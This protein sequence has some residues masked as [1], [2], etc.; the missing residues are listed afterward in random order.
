M[1]DVLVVGNGAREHALA[2]KLRQSGDVGRLI[3]APGNGG[4]AAIAENVP[5]PADDIDGLRLL[6]QERSVGLTVVGPEVPL[7]AGLANAFQKHGLPVFGATREASRLEWSKSFARQLTQDLGLPGPDFRVF[8]DPNDCE[9]FLSRHEDPIVVKADGLAA[10]KGALLCQ[11]RAEALAAAR[12]CMR[13]R[14]FGPAGETV[15]LEEFLT[16]QEISVFAF[17]DGSEASQM[18]AACDYKRALECDQGLNTGG[19]GAYAPSP[20]W[21]PALSERVH[22]E[23]IQPT[24]VAMEQRGTPYRG[25][26]YAG[27]ML[28]EEGP[29]LLEFNCR[30]GDPEAQ[31]VL[32]L[33]ESD[34]LPVLQACA[35]GSI[36]QCEVRWSVEACV[37]VVMVSGGY[38]GEY[39][40]GMTIRGLDDVDGD[41]LVFH[42]GTVAGHAPGSQGL[43]TDGGRVLTVVGQGND[44]EQARQRAYANISRIRFED[45]YYRRDIGKLAPEPMTGVP[46]LT[47]SAG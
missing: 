6:A 45:S 26:L 20:T 5:V 11:D 33:L 42:A 46:G 19:M 40:R 13:E 47:K 16:G 36:S 9:D 3:V 23:I 4:T 12:Q 7:A 2:W 27:L 29:K 38:P 28:T 34:L 24:I 22:R 15:V 32:P 31:V 30:L 35:S 17:C 18:V 14:A 21:T 1:T 44:V 25:V 41:V 39:R 37:G 10:G 43:V 8:D